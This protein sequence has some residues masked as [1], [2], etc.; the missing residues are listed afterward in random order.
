MSQPEA[1]S[2]NGPVK[3]PWWKKPVVWIGGIIASAL[4]AVLA[5]WLTVGLHHL[6]ASGHKPPGLPFAWTV[7]RTGGVL[8]LCEGWLFPQPIGRIPPRIF[9]DDNADEQWALRN[10]GTDIGG[11]AWTI[12]LQ[13]LTSEAVAIQG[14]RIRIVGKRPAPRG[15][16][17]ASQMGCGG[18]ITVR[19]FS[20]TLDAVNPHLVPVG[21]VKS[22]PYSISRGDVEE[23]RLDAYIQNSSK[24]EYLFVY[25]IDWAQGDK[26]GTAEVG[27]P[28]GQP[29]VVAPYMFNLPIYFIV[30]GRW[31]SSNPGA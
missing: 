15:T 24:Y 25:E 5:G 26:T 12:T 13:G 9:G 1:A 23:V 7:A 27:A 6:T 16:Q 21:G 22:W 14:I 11:A 20:A 8:N 18:V 17:I 10:H 19:S 30:N 29:F 2:G 28:N 3:D 31:H 4:A